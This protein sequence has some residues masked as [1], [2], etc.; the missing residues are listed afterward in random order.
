MIFEGVATSI[1]GFEAIYRFP[2]PFSKADT[3]FVPDFSYGAMENPGAVTFNE[4]FLYRHENPSV[5]EVSMRN[6]V[7]NHEYAHMWFGNTVTLKW[8]SDIWL[9]EAFADYAAILNGADQY[10]QG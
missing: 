9:N 7:I 4:K 5:G 8:W 1:K 2:Y 10:E 3:L 6:Y